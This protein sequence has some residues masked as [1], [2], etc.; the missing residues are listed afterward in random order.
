M[1]EDLR[2][3]K[4]LAQERRLNHTDVRGLQRKR[5]Q[6]SLMNWY[7]HHWK[8]GTVVSD[9]RLLT[10]IPYGVSCN[11]IEEEAIHERHIEQF[12]AKKNV[13]KHEFL[14]AFH[15]EEKFKHSDFGASNSRISTNTF[16][17]T[18]KARKVKIFN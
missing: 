12:N 16:K 17:H 8:W 5:N 11:N 3:L 1:K 15:R 13:W 6:I 9:K 14:K 2:A 7:A 4:Y 10:L 18:L